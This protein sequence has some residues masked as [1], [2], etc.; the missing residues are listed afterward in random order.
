MRVRAGASWAGGSVD[1]TAPQELRCCLQCRGQSQERAGCQR[2]VGAVLEVVEVAA[3]HPRA[4]RDVLAR[5]AQLPP[6]LRNA[7]PQIARVSP[8]LRVGRLL[9]H[10]ILDS[11]ATAVPRAGQSGG[12]PIPSPGLIDTLRLIDA[13]LSGHRLFERERERRGPSSR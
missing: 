2:G 5:Q 12:D 6:A 7:A 10:R 1:V 13:R 8:R 4:Q 11:E 3:V 9:G